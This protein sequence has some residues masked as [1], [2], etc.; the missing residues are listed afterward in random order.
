[1]TDQKQPS[2]LETWVNGGEPFGKRGEIM[3]DEK[4]MQQYAPDIKEI[5]RRNEK[6]EHLCQYADNNL[7]FRSLYSNPNIFFLSGFDEKLIEFY[8]LEISS[9]D[10]SGERF[11]VSGPQRD[12]K[13]EYVSVTKDHQKFKDLIDIV[14][15]FGDKPLDQSKLYYPDARKEY[16]ERSDAWIAKQATQVSSVMGLGALNLLAGLYPPLLPLATINFG[17][18]ISSFITSLYQRAKSRTYYKKNVLEKTE[19]GKLMLKAEETD[20]FIKEHGVAIRQRLEL[21][22]PSHVRSSGSFNLR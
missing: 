21:S 19:L 13:G 20:S 22:K 14:D 2:K 5:A 7:L 1:M 15:I 3:V 6:I 11:I 4:K 8:D 10:S 9:R 16:A 12:E 17:I 18:G